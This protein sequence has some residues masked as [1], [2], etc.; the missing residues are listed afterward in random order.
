MLKIFVFFAQFW[1]IIMHKKLIWRPFLKRMLG[2]MHLC[3]KICCICFKFH[4]THCCRK[5]I[6]PITKQ[7]VIFKSDRFSCMQFRRPTT[8]LTEDNTK[9][10]VNKYLIILKL[11]SNAQRTDIAW[12]VS[13]G[14]SES[15]RDKAYFREPETLYGRFSDFL[16]GPFYTST[17]FK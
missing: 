10:H 8:N 17:H 14:Q 6:F 15:L 7:F 9:V 2:S 3:L 1:Q 13:N 16:R 5:W 4:N 11:L 12:G